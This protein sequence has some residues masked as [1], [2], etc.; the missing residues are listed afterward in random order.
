MIAALDELGIDEARARAARPAG[1]QGRHDLAARAAR[2]LE[3][4]GG[5]RS[6][7]V[8]VVEE[9]RGLIESQAK[10]LLYHLPQRPVIDRQART[11]TA[12]TLLPSHGSLDARTRSRS[13][14]AGGCWRDR[15]DARA[16]R[17]P[18]R[19]CE[20]GRAGCRRLR[21]RPWC[22]CPIS[23]PAA[24]TAAR[25]TCPRARKALAGIG[26]H[27]MVQWMDRDTRRFTQMGGEGASWLGE[28]PFSTRPHIFQNVG[29]G[30]F[31]HSGSLAIRAAKAVR[32]QHH[33]Q[34]PLQRRR[35]HDRRP[36]DGD[37][38][39]RRAA[40]HPPA[41]GRGRAGDRRRHRRA[42]QVSRWAPPSPPACAS[43]TATSSTPCSAACARCRASRPWSTTRPVPPRSAAGASA[44][45]SPTPTSAWSSTSWSA[46]AAAIAACSRTAS[47]SSR[48]E[49]ELG[50]KRRIDQSACNKD[51]SCLK[52][53]CPSF[54]TVKGGRLRKARSAPGDVPFPV[55]PE[56]ALPDARR[57]LRH[58]G[59]RR[60]RHRRD[61]HRGPAR[62][63]G[64]SR[65]QGRGRPRHDRP[66]PEGRRR[67]HAT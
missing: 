55:L 56:P 17:A 40:D 64:P 4:G 47:R 48:V 42:G 67:R 7:C 19:S 52:G 24:R 3:A 10:E 5:R 38:Q 27:F 15:D 20:R 39:P 2:R 59:H 25:P 31:Y 43:T 44:A 60:R 13:P 36:E 41:R 35:R 9:K 53:F 14:S 65:G 28:A 12:S 34:D 22:G 33:L 32:C 37:R 1:L 51:F 30:T 66:G 8:L 18:G 63:G 29:D 49:T 61:H 6:S 16:A 54:V 50:R 11:R 21:R 62:H 26:C 57:S 23:A 46:R 58:R 45:T